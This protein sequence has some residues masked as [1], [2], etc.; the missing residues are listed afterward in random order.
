VDYN[1]LAEELLDKMRTLHKMKPHKNI[2][3]TFM[4]ETF[5]LYYIAFRNGDALPSEI[6]HE[7]GVSSARVATALNSLEEK[8]LV[9]RRIDQNDR[10]K[11]LV[12][13][14]REGKELAEK[15]YQTVLGMAAKML[16]LLGE[17][18]AREFIRITGR[19]AETIEKEN[20][21]CFN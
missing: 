6:G 5:V 10:R 12:S 7:M 14:T 20:I 9:T 13:I 4:G 15:N 17:R 3:D 11:I 16:E 19:L 1:A 2:S 21:Q 8:G 18:D